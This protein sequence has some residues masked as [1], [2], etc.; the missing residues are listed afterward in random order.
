MTEYVTIWVD[1]LPDLKRREE[2]VRC[3]DCKYAHISTSSGYNKYCDLLEIAE[4]D[5]DAERFLCVSADFFCAW[6]ER[7]DA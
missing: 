1:D 2:I 4:D 5:P 3:K 6:A 7:R